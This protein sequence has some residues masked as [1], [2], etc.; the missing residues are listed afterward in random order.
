MT[1]RAIGP[2]HFSHLQGFLV[3]QPVRRALLSV[4]DKTGVVDLARRLAALGVELVSTGGTCRTLR[5]AGL[6][7]QEVAEVTGFPEIMDG[8]VKTLHPLIHG[9]LLG[10]RGQDDAVM[11]AHGI[12][13]I[14]LLVLNLYPFE[15]TVAR[16]DCTLEE[17]V[18]QIDIGGPAM[19]RAAAKNFRHV[20]VLTEPA[21]YDAALTQ[22]E[23]GGGVGDAE[24]FALAVAAFNH[25]ANYDAAISDYLSAIG[26][27]GARGEFPGQANGRFV[28]VMDLRYGENPHQQAAFYREPVAVPGSIANYEQLQGKE[29][30]YNNINDTDAAYECVAEFDPARTA[31]VAII[32]HPNANAARPAIDALVQWTMNDLNPRFGTPRPGSRGSLYRGA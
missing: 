15:A 32:N 1:P 25:V 26:P 11:A 18:E 7:V 27:N 10:R 13:P 5:E 17:A 8:R 21:Q 23:A 30:S 20:A 6:A 9:G 14:D 31:A 24:R 22:I 12:A 19:L 3:T 16:P 28:K 4:S 2:S 29:L